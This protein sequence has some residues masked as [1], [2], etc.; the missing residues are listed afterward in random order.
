M[1]FYYVSSRYY[2]PEICR[3]INADSFASTGQGFV[4]YNM[5]AYCGNSPVFRKDI[6]GKEWELVGAGVQL[7]ASASLGEISGGAGVEVVIYWGTEEAKELGEPV[8]AVYVY[9]GGSLDIALLAEDIT[10]ITNLLTESV[11]LLKI[12]GASALEAATLTGQHSLSGAVT[13]SGFL[14]LGNEGFKDSK[15]Y[16]EGFDTFSAG[17][18]KGRINYAWS[19]CCQTVGVGVSVFGGSAGWSVM[20][21]KSYYGLLWSSACTK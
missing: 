10:N 1:G 2:D 14:V 15:N 11:E 9:G 16:T 17:Y 12:D 13:L 3:F 19:D 20:R 21:G 18:G 8:V 7:D 5:F 4:G 6:D